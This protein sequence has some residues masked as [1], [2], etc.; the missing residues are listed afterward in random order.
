MAF[1]KKAL[2]EELTLRMKC[3]A[4]LELVS[5]L[6]VLADPAHHT[7]CQ[8]WYPVVKASLSPSQLEQIEYF[9]KRYMH[10]TYMM[11]LV[12]FF[13]QSTATDVRAEDDFPALLAC[14]Q[15]LP[16]KE[17]LYYF[18]GGFQI[19]LP[20]V[21][22]DIYP[23]MD[24]TMAFLQTQLQGY[25]APEDIRSF[26]ENIPLGRQTLYNIL[27]DYYHFYFH[28]FWHNSLAMYENSFHSQQLSYSENLSTSYILSIHEHLYVDGNYIYFAY[29]EKNIPPCKI[30]LIVVNFS[31]FTFP[32]LMYNVVENAVSIYENLLMPALHQSPEEIANLIKLLAD[33]NRLQI[34]KLLQVNTHTN[35]SLSQLLNVT[36]ASVSQQ[37]KLLKDA[38]LVKSTRNKNSIYFELNQEVFAE[39]IAKIN[40]Y[41]SL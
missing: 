22:D 18:F 38:A 7:S 14:I 17:F 32:H 11:D 24:A 6:H 25:I 26:L 40:E 10:W 2:T 28:D 20:T 37:L 27:S 5:S 9:G 36:P 35:K 4:S 19:G 12:D 29:A 13:T 41:L 3:S 16:D 31:M 33:A 15:A 23:D 21:L 34:I 30:D 8:Q 1:I 39:S